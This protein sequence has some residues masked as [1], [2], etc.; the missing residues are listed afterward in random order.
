MH[1][2]S[3]FSSTWRELFSEQ[4]PPEILKRYAEIYRRKRAR[5]HR[6]LKS[7]QR[8]KDRIHQLL[9]DRGLWVLCAIADAEKIDLIDIAKKTEL[10]LWRVTEHVRSFTGWSFIQLADDGKAKINWQRVLKV[11]MYENDEHS[12]I[13]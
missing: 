12:E 10:S 8:K 13:D 9:S 2:P 5:R 6:K 1:N 7:Y 4:L 3:T 11:E